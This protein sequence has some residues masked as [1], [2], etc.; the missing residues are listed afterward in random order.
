M[1]YESG[2]W[3]K[4]LI[5]ASSQIHRFMKLRRYREDSIAITER[6][7]MIGFFAVRKLID[8]KLKLSPNFAKKLIP[9]ERFQS[10]EAM[11]SFERFEFYDHYDLDNSIPDE[12]TT[13]YLSNQFIHSLLFN[14]S[15][16]EHDRPLGVHFTSDY[17]RTKHCFHISLQQIALVFEEAAAS[18]AV[19]YR[20][21]DDPKGG[22][23]IVA[24]N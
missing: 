20:L 11:G 3:R 7:I 2:I 10:V 5:S 1:I 14:F 19:S 12:V 22:R 6:E 4:G 8:S 15:W 24:T 18:K 9:V 17:D 16:D 21:Q 23:N 13:L